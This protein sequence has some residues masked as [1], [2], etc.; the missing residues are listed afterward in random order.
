MKNEKKL[1]NRLARQPNLFSIRRAF[2]ERRKDFWIVS[3][4]WLW[5]NVSRIVSILWVLFLE[6]LGCKIRLFY[7]QTLTNWYW[8]IQGGSFINMVDGFEKKNTLTANISKTNPFGEKT[9]IT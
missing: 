8:N 2:L 3:M 6:G 5:F 7:I 4:V 1:W 9:N